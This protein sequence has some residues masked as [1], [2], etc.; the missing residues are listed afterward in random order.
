M[1]SDNVTPIRP[2]LSGV[3]KAVGPDAVPVRPKP[4]RGGGGS[5]NGP[6]GGPVQWDGP[7]LPKGCPLR[8]VGAQKTACIFLDALGQLIEAGPRELGQAHLSMYFAGDIGYL[9]DH[10][11]YYNDKGWVRS[12]FKPEDCQRSIQQACTAAGVWANFERVRGR[13][14]WRGADGGLVLH[15]GNVVIFTDRQELPDIHEGFVY[16]AGEPILQPLPSSVQLLPAHHEDAAGPK[17]LRM[18]KTWNWRRPVLDPRLFLGALVASF[19]GGALHWRPSAWIT[20]ESGSGKTT[21]MDLRRDIAAGWSFNAEDASESGISTLLG[22]DAIGVSL[23]EQ[24]N[25]QDNRRLMA[26]VELMRRAASGSLKVR[27]SASH[28]GH[29]FRSRNSFIAS[30]INAAP[31]KAQDMN[32]MGRLELD[33]LPEDAVRPVW[34]RAEAQAWGAE[35]LRRCMNSWSRFDYT[36]EEYQRDLANNGHDKRGQDTFGVLLACADLALSGEDCLLDTGGDPDRKELWRLLNADSM[37]EYTE[38]MKS[39]QACLDHLLSS[40]PR[41]WKVPGPTSI[42]GLCATFLRGRFEGVS[43]GDANPERA[44]ELLSMAGLCATIPRAGPFAGKWCL[45]VP[46]QH[47]S[48]APIFNETD[49]RGDASAVGGWIAALGRGDPALVQRGDRFRVGGV[50]KRGVVIRLDQVVEWKRE[51]RPREDGPDAEEA[52]R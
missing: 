31:L 50:Q 30:S 14:A 1:T 36:L 47:P 38:R 13:G 34:T 48:L 43:E 32:R 21:L 7:G 28:S 29:A 26:I 18:F 33:V 8:A 41:E 5:G 6:N 27:G 17:L 37:P 49:W 3:R 10:W 11:P 24:E 22:Y 51:A 16:P 42:G 52:P 35:L 15:C 2:N 12:K 19:L 44:N 40:R 39:W 9:A 23:D 25:S 4:R 46:N 20:G 45:G